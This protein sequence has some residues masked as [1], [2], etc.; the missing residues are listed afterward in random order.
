ML[1]RR[2]PADHVGVGSGLVTM[3]RQLGGALGLAV[4][5]SIGSRVAADTFTR[6]TAL[7][8]LRGEE[9][10]LTEDVL[11]GVGQTPAVP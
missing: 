11:R 6:R 2:V 5:A 8:S 4:L 1:I 9:L 7:A 10:T 3:S